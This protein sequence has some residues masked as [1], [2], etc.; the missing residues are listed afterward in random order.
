MLADSG[1]RTV[2]EAEE[3]RLVADIDAAIDR[4]PASAALQVGVG[5][6]EIGQSGE[7]IGRAHSF[8][9]YSIA[10]PSEALKVVLTQR[11]RS[12]NHWSLVTSPEWR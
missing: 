4:H 12:S 2:L 8:K 7:T 1:Q 10:D 11:P 6:Q 3:E 9:M 5:G